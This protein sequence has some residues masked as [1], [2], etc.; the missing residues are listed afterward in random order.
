[1]FFHNSL[2]LIQIYAQPYLANFDR[3]EIEVIGGV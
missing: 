2:E 1:V 3:E